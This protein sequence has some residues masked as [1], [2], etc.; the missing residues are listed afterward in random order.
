VIVAYVKEQVK[1]WRITNKKIMLD[2]KS[3]ISFAAIGEW[4][5]KDKFVYTKVQ[6]VIIQSPQ[7][8]MAS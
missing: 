6:A 5:V 3:Y 2:C 7:E 8:L 1:K 4:D